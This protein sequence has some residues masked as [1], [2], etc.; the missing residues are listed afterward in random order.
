MGILGWIT[1]KHFDEQD[2]NNN[3]H[4]NDPYWSEEDS[5]E[6]NLW[7]GPLAKRRDEE[8]AA[9][10]TPYGHGQAEARF[11]IDDM[12]RYYAQYGARSFQEAVEVTGRSAH[13]NYERSKRLVEQGHEELRERMEF[14]RGEISI[15]D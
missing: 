12:R 13:I 14:E 7:I 15:Y 4:A 8:C 11:R 2:D 9:N 6:D 5:E 1:G 10:D 3:E